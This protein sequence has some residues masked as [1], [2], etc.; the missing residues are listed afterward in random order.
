MVNSNI[1]KKN[2]TKE[3]GRFVGEKKKFHL[4]SDPAAAVV[5]GGPSQAP[6]GL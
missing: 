2:Q 1:K 4:P 6:R 3:A 5:L